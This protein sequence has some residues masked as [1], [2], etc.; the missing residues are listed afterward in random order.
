MAGRVKTRNNTTITYNHLGTAAGY[1][2]YT[3][4]LDS[5]AYRVK[6]STTGS[7]TNYVRRLDGSVQI[8][9]GLSGALYA[10]YIYRGGGLIAY[11][12][13]LKMGKL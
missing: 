10:K 3:Y 8:E 9:Y 7:A 11:I 2:A 12:N 1:T 13:I 4:L 6:K 5:D